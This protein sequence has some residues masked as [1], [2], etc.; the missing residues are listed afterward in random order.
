MTNQIDPRNAVAAVHGDASAVIKAI[1]DFTATTFRTRGGRLGSGM[2]S[3]IEALWVYYMNQALYNEGGEA[4][5]CELAWLP[6]HQPADFACIERGSEWLPESRAGE[7]FRIEAKSMNVGVDE[8]KG[9]FT[10]LAKETSEL[11]QL[12]IIV[13]AWTEHDHHYVWPEIYDYFIGP[14]L[15]VIRMRDRLHVAR[16]G[17]FV[18][19]VSC[20]DGCDPEHCSHVGEPL[21]AAGKRERR[22]GPAATKPANVE[23]AANFGGLLRMIKTSGPDAT[24]IFREERA[25][26]DVCHEFVSFIHRNFSNEEFGQYKL[27]DWRS[28]AHD[29]DIPT[30]GKNAPTLREE[31]ANANPQYRDLLRSLD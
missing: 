19:A 15:P 25:N 1:N 18:E 2:G 27:S 24:R 7:L 10:N 29:L 22:S 26:C 21:N 31:I 13:W 8:A 6:D 23:Y 14:S 3:L 12:L 28:I 11:D 30:A 17:N 16:G 9:H 4:R 5:V 20:P